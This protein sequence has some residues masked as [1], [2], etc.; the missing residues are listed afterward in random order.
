MGRD[1]K[2]RNEK[3]IA[4]KKETTELLEKI[5]DLIYENKFS[6]EKLKKLN[7][8]LKRISENNE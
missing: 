2:E 5:I 1:L 3:Y 8:N 7:E 6:E 4:L